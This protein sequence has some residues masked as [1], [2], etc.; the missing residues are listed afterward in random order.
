MIELKNSLGS[1]SK[2]SRTRISKRVSFNVS[3]K[4]ESK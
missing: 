1:R 3:N 4:I 2:N